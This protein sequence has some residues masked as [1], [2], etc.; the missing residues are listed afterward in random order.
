MLLIEHS[1]G[2]EMLGASLGQA[3]FNIGNAAGAF[4][5]GIPLTLGYGY[6]SPQWV[7]AA[8]AVTG[9]LI[10]SIMLMKIKRASL[11]L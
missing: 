2:A 8:L 1:K 9:A 3:S 7:A 5:G 4:F 6:A 11:R 10:A